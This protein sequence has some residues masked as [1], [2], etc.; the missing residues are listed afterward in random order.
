[1]KLKDEFKQIQIYQ[2]RK[3]AKVAVGEN[4]W[5]QHQVWQLKYLMS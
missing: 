5:K 2:I 1:M 3:Y 4:W